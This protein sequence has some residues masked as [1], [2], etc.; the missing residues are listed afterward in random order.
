MKKM[1]L[2]LSQ[3]LKDAFVTAL[4]ALCIGVIILSMIMIFV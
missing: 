3:S 2:K 4:I 1:K